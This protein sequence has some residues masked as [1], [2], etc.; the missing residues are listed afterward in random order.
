[1]PEST[2]T[3]CQSRL[4]PPVRDLGFGHRLFTSSVLYEIV[5]V[6]DNTRH[7]KALTQKEYL[8]NSSI[9]YQAF[10]K[11]NDLAHWVGSFPLLPLFFRQQVVSLSQSACVSPVEL[12]DVM[13]GGGRGNI[14]RRRES[15]VLY[16]PL[17]L[18]AIRVHKSG[19]LFKN[20]HKCSS[21]SSRKVDS[22][23]QKAGK[24]Y[25]WTMALQLQLHLLSLQDHNS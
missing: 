17:I 7:C 16:N 22:C 24:L 15:L 20:C 10:S 3:L 12:T 21:L 1:M 9:E 8:M 4:Y 14:T 13:G 19:Q 25:S 23:Y 6:A 18:S 11:S 5:K 2:L